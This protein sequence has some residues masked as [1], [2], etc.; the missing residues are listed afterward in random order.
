MRG[1]ALLLATTLLAP[2]GAWSEES[3]FVSALSASP[4]AEE[5][6]ISELPVEFVVINQNRSR[7]PCRA[8][9]LTYTIR[10]HLVGPSDGLAAADDLGLYLHGAT[11]G[12]FNW[13]LKDVPGYD[14]LAELA[15]LGHTSIGIDRLGFDSSGHPIG[16]QMCLGSEADVVSQIIEQLK[17]G[18]YLMDG[19]PGASFERVAVVGY[20]AGGA[21]AEII[22]HS[23]GNA[24]A[25]GIIAW[26]DQP[27]QVHVRLAP[28]AAQT[29]LTG[30]EPVEDDGTGPTGYA[31]AWPSWDEQHPDA[32]AN[33]EP[34]VLDAVETRLNRDP[35]GYSGSLGTTML[36]NNILL[37]LIDVP[38]LLV[39]AEK[40]LVA[41]RPVVLPPEDRIGS[42][43]VTVATIQDAGHTVML[44]RTAPTFRAVLAEWLTDHGY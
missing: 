7:V 42:S 44:Q 1:L 29:C 11:L 24:D 2:A 28:H 35:C 30:G 38:V 13:R 43:D 37:P 9:H 32:F 5:V 25:L 34:E 19:Q 4:G 16:D 18:T 10:G 26:V 23:F 6:Q 41:P 15:A 14:T 12:E 8:D 33:T 36:V 39:Y 40:D 31:Y 21:I 22:G 27:T 17:A 20:S 3:S